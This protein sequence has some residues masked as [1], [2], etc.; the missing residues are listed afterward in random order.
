[1]TL[2]SYIAEVLIPFFAIGAF[3]AVLLTYAAVLGG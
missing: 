1:M 3:V 2:R